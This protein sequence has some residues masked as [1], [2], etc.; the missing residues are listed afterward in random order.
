MI[1][2]EKAKRYDEII[3]I[4]NANI[5]K[6][7]GDLQYVIAGSCVISDIQDVI[8]DDVTEVYD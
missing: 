7:D 4:W 6:D 8:A 1:N 3:R 5:A 2:E